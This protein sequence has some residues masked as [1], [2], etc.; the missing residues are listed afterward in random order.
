MIYFIDHLMPIDSDT[1]QYTA[2]LITRLRVSPEGQR[3][4]S[5]FVEKSLPRWQAE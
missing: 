1:I 3:G 5:A 2:D 4:I